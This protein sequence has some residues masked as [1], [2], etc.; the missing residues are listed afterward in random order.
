MHLSACHGAYQLCDGAIEA[1]SS[2]VH[3]RPP[4]CRRQSSDQSS[5]DRGRYINMDRQQPGLRSSEPHNRQP[6][7]DDKVLSDNAG[8]LPDGHRHQPGW[9]WASHLLARCDSDNACAPRPG[10]STFS[11]SIWCGPTSCVCMMTP[12]MA[13][14]GLVWANGLPCCQVHSADVKGEQQI[15]GME[16]YCLP[17]PSLNRTTMVTPM[18]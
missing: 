7:E 9:G 18:T 14:A 15:T 17:G 3:D 11:R 13:D 6:G 10:C 5:K 8:A 1:H 12:T 16:R 4:F 2:P